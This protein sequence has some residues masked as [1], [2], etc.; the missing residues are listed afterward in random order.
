MG[1]KKKR[2][3]ADICEGVK[4]VGGNWWILTR[5][6]E[7]VANCG[8]F[9]H[10]R[11]ARFRE[12]TTHP[13]WRQR[14]SARMRCQLVLAQGFKDQT[15]EQ[16]VMVVEYGRSR[17]RIYKSVGFSLRSFQVAFQWDLK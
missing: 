2:G 12:V 14:G 5:T 16:L 15:V 9:R 3:A 7:F 8:L 6:S 17:E 4:T 10:G 11:T 13:N 1:L